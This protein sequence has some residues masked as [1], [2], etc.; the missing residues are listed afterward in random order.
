MVGSLSGRF[1]SRPCHAGTTKVFEAD[2]FRPWEGREARAT[3]CCFS[4]ANRQTS[5]HGIGRRNEGR[6]ASHKPEAGQR[7]VPPASLQEWRREAGACAANPADKPLP[8]GR[9]R[10]TGGARPN[11]AG[12]R[13]EAPG[14]KRKGGGGGE[15]GG[16]RPHGWGLTAGPGSRAGPER[17]APR[18]RRASAGAGGRRKKGG[19]EEGDGL[20]PPL[21]EGGAAPPPALRS[22]GAF[23]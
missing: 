2:E 22:K 13:A 10:Q 16:R 17:R 9:R 6:G 12:G 5:P 1:P 15:E 3:S 18:A 21:P 23:F 4:S 7:P 14:P 11:Q 19:G 8:T 20:R